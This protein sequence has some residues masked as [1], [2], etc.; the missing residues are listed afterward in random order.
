[1]QYSAKTYTTKEAGKG[2]GDE[3]C[4]CGGCGLCSLLSLAEC[5]LRKL[6]TLRCTKTTAC[7]LKHAPD[8][9]GTMWD[10]GHTSNCC[11]YNMLCTPTVVHASSIVHT[12]CL[13]RPTV[14]ETYRLGLNW[15]AGAGGTRPQT[16]RLYR[17][18]CGEGR[19]AFKALS[20]RR[21]PPQHQ[22][23][24]AGGHCPMAGTRRA[25]G[26]VTCS[27]ICD[28]SWTRSPSLSGTAAPPG[29]PWS[30]VPPAVEKRGV[31]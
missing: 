1:M 27:L 15:L 22:K 2:F 7:S 29:F 3:S 26:P 20:S 9:E 4:I 17:R 18:P 25:S 16:C 31:L 23:A 24:A 21:Q 12:N 5:A 11:E 8:V 6:K 10:V 19:G 30:P 14:G 13:C 28:L